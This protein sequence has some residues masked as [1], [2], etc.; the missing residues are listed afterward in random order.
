[1]IVVSSNA[2]SE[3]MPAKLEP[4]LEIDCTPRPM[5]GRRPPYVTFPTPI[6]SAR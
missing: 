3:E 1:M 4:T 6:E 5:G 2:D